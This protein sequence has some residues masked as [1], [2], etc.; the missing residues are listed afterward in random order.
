VP[1]A[2]AAAAAGVVIAVRSLSDWK[3]VYKE[4]WLDRDG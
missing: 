1:L 3:R 4:L 2:A